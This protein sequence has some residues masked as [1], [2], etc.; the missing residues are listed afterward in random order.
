MQDTGY[1][2][3]DTGCRM[4]DTGYRIQD[5]GYR[6]QDAGCRIQDT[7]CRMQ[8]EI[9]AV[10][11]LKQVQDRR[12]LAKTGRGEIALGSESFPLKGEGNKMKH[13]RVLSDG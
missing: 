2:M 3:Q 10:A 13:E 5:A 4:Q 7:G 11:I 9:A 1:R 12:S 6:I 8:E